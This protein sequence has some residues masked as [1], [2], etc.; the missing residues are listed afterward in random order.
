MDYSLLVGV[1]AK[2]RQLSCGIIDYLRQYTWDKQ[3]ETW[4]K[5]SLVVPKNQLPTVISPIE[6][7]MRFR[8]FIGTHFLGVPDH[9]CSQR[10]SYPCLLCSMGGDGEDEDEEGCLRSKSQKLGNNGIDSGHAKLEELGEH[11]GASHDK[12][13][14]WKQNGF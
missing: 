13:K 1:D 3:L 5:S 12:S 10:S 14:E 7:R 4:V 6:Y 2:R 9:W 8:K 11:G